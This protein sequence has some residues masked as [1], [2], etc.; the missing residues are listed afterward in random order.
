MIDEDIQQ[1]D[2]P[3]S[4][5]PSDLGNSSSCFVNIFL[6]NCFLRLLVNCVITE[7]HNTVCNVTS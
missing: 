6:T 1:Q 7:T 4:P 5:L 2:C 3:G